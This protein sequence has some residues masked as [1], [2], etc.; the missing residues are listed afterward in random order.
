[1]VTSTFS[2]YDRLRGNADPPVPGR[3]N[4]VAFS[5]HQGR[6]G[7]HTHETSIEVLWGPLRDIPIASRVHGRLL[8]GA[9]ERA[10]DQSWHSRLR[11]WK[12]LK[13]N[14]PD[15]AD[16]E[17]ARGKLHRAEGGD[18]SPPV[19]DAQTQPSSHRENLQTHS[20]RSRMENGQTPAEGANNVVPD[21]ALG[22][23]AEE[24]QDMSQ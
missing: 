8:A 24:T 3:L 2:Q 7:Q 23:P 17:I 1:M 11:I 21:L 13:K 19:K 18:T 9:S 15:V 6:P 22:E 5:I 14:R 10:E 12:G 16:L 4:R 20:L